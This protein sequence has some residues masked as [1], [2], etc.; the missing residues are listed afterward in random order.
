MKI[1]FSFF[2]RDPE[3]SRYSTIFYRPIQGWTHSSESEWNFKLPLRE[4]ALSVAVGRTW[5]AVATSRDWIRV[6]RFSGLQNIVYAI[7]GSSKFLSN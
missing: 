1:L 2:F 5:A 7:P 4:M 3:E 6:F